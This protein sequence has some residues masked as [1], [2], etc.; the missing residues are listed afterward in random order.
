V[1]GVLAASSALAAGPSGARL[2][3]P[4]TA[5]STGMAQSVRGFDTPTCKKFTELIDMWDLW[6]DLGF[7][8]A[9]ETRDAL[10]EESQK[11]G[12]E[13]ILVRGLY[14]GTSDGS[15]GGPSL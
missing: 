7:E 3:T 9:E 12:C 11:A 2:S 10:L 15:E 1:L 6:D 5:S 13:I 14:T 4:T 8:G